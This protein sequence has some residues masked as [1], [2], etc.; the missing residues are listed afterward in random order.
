MTLGDAAVK[1]LVHIQDF[2]MDFGDTTVTKDPSSDVRA[3]ES[4]GFLDS[5]GSGTTTILRAL[6]G[7]HQPTDPAPRRPVLC[8]AA[9]R[10]TGNGGTTS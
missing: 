2:R 6:L 3:G 1:P 9:G 4:F 5:N 10:L 7:T 8:P